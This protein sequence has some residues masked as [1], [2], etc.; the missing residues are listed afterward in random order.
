M[1]LAF[2]PSRKTQE[3]VRYLLD[4]N[5][6]GELT[7]EESAELKRFGEIERLMQLVKARAHHY[8]EEH[9]ESGV[10]SAGAQAVCEKTRLRL[11]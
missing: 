2:R 6:A 1:V 5:K 10:H 4:R 8:V 9:G 7:E 3:R 11:L